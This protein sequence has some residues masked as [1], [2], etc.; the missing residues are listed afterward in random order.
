MNES[1]ASSPFMKQL[2]ETLPHSVVVK[3]RDASMIG[4]PDCSV[5][6][7][8]HVLWLEFKFFDWLGWMEGLSVEARAQRMLDLSSKKA[9]KQRAM[10]EDLDRAAGSLYITWVNKTGVY[11]V[12]PRD[13]SKVVFV[14]TTKD[15]VRVVRNLMERWEGTPVLPSLY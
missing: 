8:G 10:M 6:F 3:H 13:I 4:L 15:A 5:T 14:E 2:R 12:N 1:S 11:I 9:P 7:Q